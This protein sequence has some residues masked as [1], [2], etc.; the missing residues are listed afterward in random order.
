[1]QATYSP[2][3][4]K[5][6]LYSHT[7]LD[8]ET[9]AKVK[10][11]GFRWAP[12]Q[13]L[14]FAP[15][16]SP[17]RE[18]LLL[19]LCDEIGD[20][21]TSLV[22]RAE[23]RAER[24]ETYS[25]NRAADAKNAREAVSA[26]ADNI[27]LGQPIRVGH[28]SEK[29][30]RRDA[31]KIENGMRRA[32]KMWDQ[33]KYWTDRAAGALAHA[34]YKEIPAVRARR[35][36]TL[37][38]EQRG[39]ERDKA[40]AENQLKLWGE[41]D[42]QEKALRL[43]GCHPDAG[44]LTCATV[45]D[46]RY[47][48]YDVLRPDEERY[49]DCPAMTFEQ[50]KEIAARRYPATISYCDRWIAHYS[51]RLAYE[52][53]ML[54][55]SGGLAAD[56]F[57]F[58]VGG[59][60]KRRGQWFVILKVNMRKGALQSLTVAG[61]WKTTIGLDEIQDYKEPAPGDWEKARAVSLTPPLCNY[62]G[63]GFL[64][65]TEAEYKATVPKW[66]DFPKT[67][68]IKATADAVCHRVR[69][70]RKLGG[71][72]WQGI[73]VFL[74]DK[75]ETRP[76]RPEGPAPAL[77]DRELPDV[78]APRPMPAPQPD[79]AETE[80]MRQSLKEGIKV[81]SAPQLFPTPPEL[82]ARLVAAAFDGIGWGVQIA[83][84]MHDRCRILEPSAGTGNLIEA[85]FKEYHAYSSSTH[86]DLVA[87]ELNNTLADGIRRRLEFADAVGCIN[88]EVLAGDFLGFNGEL[89]KFDRVIMNPP[90]SNG[91]DIKHIEHARGLLQPGGRLV[92]ICANGPRQRAQLMPIADDWQDLGPGAFLESGTGVNAA[93]C[94]FNA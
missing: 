41:V 52:R 58:K 6:R 17:D 84:G 4:N 83:A 54:A 13:E 94:I 44:W 7:R 23:Q 85:L 53:A 77:P 40:K 62:P 71:N 25:D 81:V 56:K 63:E 93:L 82:A 65:Q 73:G 50:V 12:K 33:S 14:F 38:A 9:Y 39:R 31:E 57:N 32:I 91:Q 3:D 27:P 45:G 88:R 42:S 35:I 70:Q 92:A 48:A 67:I 16:W 79:K 36:K 37:V 66:S 28:H 46:L 55:E 22:A 15:A 30:A 11:A 34:K 89:G 19:D 18:D 76:A 43:A 29:H 80:A 64:H 2:E 20:E 87:V 75:K 72:A 68:T 90:F 26:I 61:H 1:M 74:T 86:F 51:N 78:R 49:K 10:A 59:Q 24:F 5:L 8:S 69:N 47:H 21:D 60:V